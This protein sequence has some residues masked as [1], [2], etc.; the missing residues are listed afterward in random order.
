MFALPVP[1]LMPRRTPL[2]VAA[3]VAGAAALA[4]SVA[5][6]GP[7]ALALW[8]APDLT[9]LAG[10]FAAPA[11]PG[12]LTPRAVP[13]YNAAHAL[14]GPVALLTAGAVA[15]PVVLG[16]GALWA[17]HVLLDRAMGYGLRTPEG[18][19]RG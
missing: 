8:L 9:M 12:L 10:G 5:L 13:F 15:G 14:P 11:E 17:S 1:T 3:G 19:Q 18:R 4:A 7:W 16:L 6:L 2:R